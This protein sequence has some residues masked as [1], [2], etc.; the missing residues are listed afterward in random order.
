MLR[1]SW[2]AVASRCSPLV[3]HGSWVVT[4]ASASFV[5]QFHRRLPR[6]AQQHTTQRDAASSR[7]YALYF[8]SSSYSSSLRRPQCV[9]RPPAEPSP[10]RHRSEHDSAHD[11]AATSRRSRCDKPRLPRAA[12]ADTFNTLP[13][14]P[15]H[16]NAPQT[17]NDSDSSDSGSSS[18]FA[19]SSTGSSSSAPP[20][21]RKH[22]G[23][24]SVLSP[25]SW[26][27]I[28]PPAHSA[29][30]YDF[31][32]LHHHQ[33]RSRR[34][35]S[36]P[37][38][39]SSWSSSSGASPPPSPSRRRRRQATWLPSVPS[40]SW[41]PAST[42][43]RTPQLALA[44]LIPILGLL[45]ASELRSQHNL[46]RAWAAEYT[47]RAASHMPD[48]RGRL[49]LA[50]FREGK[51]RAKRDGARAALEY[52]ELHPDEE[53]Q[54]ADAAADSWPSWW[55]S[56]DDVGRSPF[57]H[58]PTP[59]E[60]RRVLF[61]TSYDDYLERMNT[62]TYEIVDGEFSSRCAGDRCGAL[63]APLGRVCGCA[64]RRGPMWHKSF[65]RQRLARRRD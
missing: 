58:V 32:P 3:R 60:P 24:T 65:A 4:C 49:D 9:Y 48:A 40:L 59:Q 20:P 15:R 54:L 39:D 13:H 6:P 14:P 51:L 29:S 12:D 36:P 43:R 55:G 63:W 61:L 53:R 50:A 52:D 30:T 56:T 11:H 5:G 45:L 31:I 16:A 44:L 23:R 64:R 47:A 25:T 46:R 21:P 42:G 38:S 7:H 22:R 57:D 1:R 17:M 8:Y 34:S 10:A 33:R 26:F 35:P 41:L 19:S 37:S 28:T 18:S 2:T 27:S 62:H